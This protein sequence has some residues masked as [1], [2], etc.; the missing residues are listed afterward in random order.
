MHAPGE[1]MGSLYR[2]MNL[3]QGLTS[4]SHNCFVITPFNY[5][6]DWGPLVEFIS[7]PV[8]SS[9]S[10]TNIPKLLYKVARKI[11]DIKILSNFTLINPKVLNGIINQISKR[12]LK[13]LNENPIH[14]DVIIGETEI[15][16]LVLTRIKD[17]LKIPIIVDYQNYWP[18]EL[19]EHRIIK[20]YGRRYKFLV[21]LEKEVIKDADFIITICQ[22]M[23]DFLKIHFDKK[24]HFK[25]KAVNNG[26]VPVLDNPKEKEFPPKII[27][28]G[29]V[30][31]RSNFKLFLESMKYVLKKY[32]ESQVFITKKGEK[33]KEVIKLVKKM[34]LTVNFYWKETIEEYFDLLSECHIGVVTSTNELTRKLGFVAKVYDYF[35]VGIPVVGNDIGGFTSIIPKKNVGALSSND[36]RDLADKIIYFIENPD[37]AYECGKRGINLLKEELSVKESSRNLINCIKKIQ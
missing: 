25:I 28:S 24:Y 14:L 32:P 36:P 2:V 10:G 1:S 30:V 3:C 8:I 35:S 7:I 26:G 21:E 6:E 12:L 22:T 17:K 4:M 16:G 20:R 29:I 13:Y 18:E 33:L 9:K 31:H 23:A 5:Y 37:L 15:G 34:K 11:L 27:N 19:V